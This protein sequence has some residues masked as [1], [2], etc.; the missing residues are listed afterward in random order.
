MSESILQEKSYKF[1]LRI[2]KLSQY[3]ND[4][5]HEFV[6]SKKILDSG[7]SI[8]VLVE[9]AKQG[10]N[11]ADFSQKLSVANKE[12]FKTNFW[13]R[14]LRDG[15]FLSEKQAESL[16][17]DCEELQKMLIATIKTTKTTD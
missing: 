17:H 7:T 5:K 11:R 15:G 6:L 10:E 2:L 3:L 13:L 14:L 4:E 1:A 16:L 12:A 9:E 8:G